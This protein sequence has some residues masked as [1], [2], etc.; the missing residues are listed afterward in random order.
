MKKDFSQDGRRSARRQ[1]R[2]IS[3]SYTQLD[4]YKRQVLFVHR[5]VINQTFMRRVFFRECILKN[6]GV[7]SYVEAC[8]LYTSSGDLRFEQSGDS[9]FER[10]PKRSRR[11]F[12]GKE[13]DGDN[14]KD[15]IL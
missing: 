7:A 1:N 4:V 13:P 8:L 15:C 11:Y 2:Y 5:S 6:A 3:V 9:F 14:G 12:Y 10:E